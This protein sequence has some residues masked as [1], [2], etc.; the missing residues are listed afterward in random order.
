MDTATHLRIASAFGHWAQHARQQGPQLAQL[1]DLFAELLSPQATAPALRLY[2]ERAHRL[3]AGPA[4]PDAPP[5]P[6]FRSSAPSEALTLRQPVYA[7]EAQ[8][9]LLPLD[10]PHS[11]FALLAVHTSANAD[12][13]LLAL[14]AAQLSLALPP[15]NDP[16]DHAAYHPAQNLAQRLKRAFDEL[17]VGQD[18]PTMA[19]VVAQHILPDPTQHLNLYVLY[20]EDEGYQVTGWDPQPLSANAVETHVSLAAPLAWDDLAAALRSRLLDGDSLLL[21]APH[22][23]NAADLGA[24]FRRW[25]VNANVQAAVLCPVMIGGR[26]VAVMI[27]TGSAAAPLDDAHYSAL[28]NLADQMGVLAQVRHLLEQARSARSAMDNFTLAN[29]LISAAGDYGY[30]AQALSYTVARHMRAVALTRFNQPLPAD[31]P[32]AYRLLMGVGA[33]DDVLPVDSTLR[34]PDLQDPAVLAPL[35]EGQPLI[36][37]DLS[38]APDSL[39]S[40]TTRSQYLQLGATWAACFGL[41]AGDQLI[42]TVDVLNDVPV[43]LDADTIASY[44]ALADQIA[45]QVRTRQLYEETL[46]AQNLAAQ[47]VETNRRIA[48]AADSGQM[49]AAVKDLLPPVVRMVGILH[50]DEPLS[51]GMLPHLI[52][53]E[54]YAT[55]GGVEMPGHSFLIDADSPQLQALVSVLMQGDSQL[56]DLQ[57]SRASAPFGPLADDMRA[58]NLNAFAVIGLRSIGRLL[59][60][61]VFGATDTQQLSQLTEDNLGAVA[62]Q[63]AVAIENRDLLDQTADALDF[64]AAQYEM[65]SALFRA[66]TPYEM[67]SVLVR[68]SQDAY[69]LATL[70]LVDESGQRVRVVA[71]IDRDTPRDSDRE[72]RTLFSYPIPDGLAN[73][74]SLVVESDDGQSLSLPLLSREG[75]HLLGVVRF[76]NPDPVQLSTERQR[77]LR[78]LA[79][80]MSVTL[81]NTTLLRQTDRALQETRDIS[82]LSRAIS[83]SE[84]SLQLLTAIQRSVAPDAHNIAL[85]TIERDLMSDVI[86]EFIL[87]SVVQGDHAERLKLPLQE[88][89]DLEVL[90]AFTAKWTGREREVEFVEQVDADTALTDPVYAYYRDRWEEIRS[91]V[92]VPIIDVDGM[93]QQIHISFAQPR[94]FSERDRRLYAALRDQ[95]SVVLKNHRLVLDLST[96]AARLG[97]QVRV[98]RSIN[99]LAVTMGS[100][101]DETALMAEAAEAL[102]AALPIDHCGISLMNQDGRSATV[103]AEYPAQGTVGIVLDA[104]NAL[105]RMIMDNKNPI[106]IPDIAAEQ[107]LQA[108]S[109]ERLIAMGMKSLYL[110]PMVDLNERYLG[111]VGLEVRTQ[112]LNFSEEMI[113]V[114]R[115]ITSQLVVGLTNIRQLY[116]MQ[117]QAVQLQQ[118]T[119]FSQV[120]QSQLNLEGIIRSVAQ[121]APQ[122]LALDTLNIYLRSSEAEA[123]VLALRTLGGHIQF[124]GLGR[125]LNAKRSAAQTALD[126]GQ[127]ISVDDSE[128]SEVKCSSAPDYLSV[129]A[130]PVTTRGAIIG[131]IEIA[132]RD[133]YRY[134]DTDSIIFSQLVNQVGIAMENADAYTQSQRLA[135]S[136]ALV[137]DISSQLQEQIDVESILQLTLNELGRALGAKSGRIRL[138]TV[139]APR[140]KPRP[141]T[142]TPDDEA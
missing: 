112:I 42:G 66:Q 43:P 116:N 35:R 132:Q 2:Q 133:A 7:D 18:L 137:N 84:D 28:S 5:P 130:A 98:M 20:Y 90:L 53:V 50:F 21:D 103:V 8:A 86:R 48:A 91:I 72:D 54:A 76:Q 27:A 62:G 58:R 74:D 9:W 124:N 63:V 136:K 88:H 92:V 71:Q 45:Q 51:P 89:V 49:A 44:V 52:R 93:P 67:L 97:S 83:G 80:Q 1:Q 36:I 111:A 134:T 25:L 12:P 81:E 57:N 68:F 13:E 101:R 41:R 85:V 56:I 126:S 73:G 38:A 22:E 64:V 14:L 128:R 117:R 113:D 106:L 105:Q 29:R 59:G 37:E 55:E 40:S 24:R 26:S 16:D 102:V 3:Q 31:T 23:A 70:G 121:Q 77:A 47:L 15:A 96:S 139:D 95:A 108:E 123:P 79:N 138:G 69:T 127:L 46:A 19:H 82:E 141:I 114:A 131:V 135:R 104:D 61:L 11:D 60:V 142:P 119:Q 4:T 122:V 34:R 65:S 110:F 39:L 94:R 87:Y 118:L 125:P 140:R 115:T 33:L 6:E 30:L 99:H 10:A 120:I 75:E 17:V 100:I 32:P 107:G 129:L 78:T 109:R